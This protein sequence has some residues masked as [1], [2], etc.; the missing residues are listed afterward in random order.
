MHLCHRI[1][2]KFGQMVADRFEV[3]VR[4]KALGKQG[5][6]KRVDERVALLRRHIGLD[7]D[8]LMPPVNDIIADQTVQIARQHMVD[9]ER[10]F[11]VE[12]IMVR[13]LAKGIYV[14]DG[15]PEGRGIGPSTLQAIEQ[16]V[17][18]LVHGR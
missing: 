9:A 6:D 16:D 5:G 10:D 18:N 17:L 13:D 3:V 12:L 7:R 15:L 14:P 8:G 2:C 11:D 4:R 1:D